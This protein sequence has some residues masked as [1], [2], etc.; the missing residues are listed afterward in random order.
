MC[1][2]S[3]RILCSIQICTILPR[4]R[5][6]DVSGCNL[7]LQHVESL[8]TMA[9][10]HKRLASINVARNRTLGFQEAK[11]L[12]PLLKGLSFE[13][14][15]VPLTT[16]AI[17][18]ISCLWSNTENR[19][20]VEMDVTGTALAAPTQ[21]LIRKVLVANKET[22]RN[23]DVVS[24]VSSEFSDLSDLSISGELGWST[25]DMGNGDSPGVA[26]PL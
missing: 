7:K 14:Q 22:P 9:V 19:R 13:C 15:T 20:I 25:S 26:L 11:L 12:L 4:L 2:E 6:L 5:N 24:D 8:C 16:V 21:A 23:D 10:K 17:F 18:S 3:L 1:F